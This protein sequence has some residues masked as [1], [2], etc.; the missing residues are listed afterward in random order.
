MPGL[1]WVS[2]VVPKGRPP[3]LLAP[4]LPVALRNSLRKLLPGLLSAFTS[5][6]F[7]YRLGENDRGNLSLSAPSNKRAP[8]ERRA[9]GRRVDL[10]L[11][12]QDLIRIKGPGR[13]A[14]S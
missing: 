9:P 11:R 7:P 4:M 5:S 8:S 12:P 1:T 14:A 13:E 2:S 6:P 10:K 3:S